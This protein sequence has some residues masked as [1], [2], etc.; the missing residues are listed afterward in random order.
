MKAILA[1]VLE[2]LKSIKLRWWIIY[3]VFAFLVYIHFLGLGGV[4][5]MTV[6]LILLNEKIHEI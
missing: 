2:F 6:V 1:K 4:V 5:G 3:A